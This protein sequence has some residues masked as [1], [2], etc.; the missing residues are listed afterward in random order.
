MR[1]K[2]NLLLILN[3]FLFLKVVA[4]DAPKMTNLKQDKVQIKYIITEM[5]S[6]F[7]SADI[8]NFTDFWTC[9]C[10]YQYDS[11]L[12]NFA[13]DQELE[14]F[15]NAF[16]QSLPEGYERS[17]IY[18]FDIE[19]I[20]PKEALVSVLWVRINEGTPSDY[21]GDIYKLVKRGDKWKV[22]LASAY[23]GSNLISL[24]K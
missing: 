2:S 22:I 7:A 17:M 23:N 11:Q 15:I 9:P 1:L 20:D 18:D 5:A 6:A 14:V 3:L 21:F 10:A 19:I 24:S 4:Q 13:D 16:R 12:A 8:G